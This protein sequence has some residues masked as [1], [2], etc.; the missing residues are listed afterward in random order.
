MKKGY[1]DVVAIILSHKI[2][3]SQHFYAWNCAD[4][5]P[6]I[7]NPESYKLVTEGH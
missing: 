5:T 6:S 2:F 1:I 3:I 7:E 4:E